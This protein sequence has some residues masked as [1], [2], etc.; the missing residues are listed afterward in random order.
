MC[1]RVVLYL[2]LYLYLKAQLS[3]LARL[4]HSHCNGADPLTDGLEVCCVFY[5]PEPVLCDL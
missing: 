2:Y 3:W 5:R 1:V 4:D